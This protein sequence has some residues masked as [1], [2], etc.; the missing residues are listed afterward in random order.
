[1][2]CKC[3]C[4]NQLAPIWLFVL[5]KK[6]W[7]ENMF[8]VIS[9]LL[10]RGGYLMFCNSGVNEENHEKRK[11]YYTYNLYYRYFCTNQ[12]F[13]KFVSPEQPLSGLILPT[14]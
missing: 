13:K 8:V 1:M 5:H 6:C 3:Q 7:L 11:F 12:F 14:N 9:S 2:E 10:D 4:P